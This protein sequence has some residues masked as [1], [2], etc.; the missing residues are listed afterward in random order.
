ML[1][2]VVVCVATRIATRGAQDNV[3][4]VILQEGEVSFRLVLVNP[5]GVFDLLLDSRKVSTQGSDRGYVGFALRFQTS[6]FVE[7]FAVFCLNLPRTESVS[8][9]LCGKKCARQSLKSSWHSMSPSAPTDLFLHFNHL[10]RLLLSLSF[11]TLE[12]FRERVN[13]S[14]LVCAGL[15]SR[16]GARRRRRRGSGASG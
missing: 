6:L 3:A 7:E 5:R 12:L 9:E 16:A 4:F 8:V 14:L 15:R 1:V 13:Q 11:C 10:S 2:L